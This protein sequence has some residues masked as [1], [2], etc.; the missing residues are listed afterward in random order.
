MV[1][2]SLTQALNIGE[3]D[4]RTQALDTVIARLAEDYGAPGWNE[5]EQ[6]AGHLGHLPLVSFDLWRR[7][8]H[9][10]EA[11]VALALRLH[12]ELTD[13]FVAKFARELPFVWELIPFQTWCRGTERL[14]RQCV[15]W[16]GGPIL[17][18]RQL[19]RRLEHIEC[20]FG[21]R[22]PG[23]AKLLGLVRCF[24]LSKDCPEVRL[25]ASPSSLPLFDGQLFDGPESSLQQLLRGHPD[26]DWP[27]ADETLTRWIQTYRSKS[28]QMDGLFPRQSL[29]FKNAV[30][31]TPILLAIQVATG[32]TGVWFEHPRNIHRLRCF[33]AFDPDWF[34]TAFD[35]TIARCL[36]TGLLRPPTA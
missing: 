16:F 7:L 17:W 20:E 36:A 34:D 3:R 8:V 2:G 18:R 28:P 15:A 6:L 1:T 30:I 10:P 22:H 24:C 14:Q 27:A 23:L 31:S 9:S 11:M 25:M 35:L 26:D 4:K 12:T 19:E 21:S 13:E 29:G 32:T 5:L 33:R